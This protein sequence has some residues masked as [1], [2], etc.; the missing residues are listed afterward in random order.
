[1]I[2]V[3]AEPGVNSIVDDDQ[4][5]K[6]IVVTVN[7][8]RPRNLCLKVTLNVGRSFELRAAC[9]VPGIATVD[10]AGA[11]VPAGVPLTV[12]QLDGLR[13]QVIIPQMGRLWLEYKGIRIAR[14]EP[15]SADAQIM[16]LPLS[17]IQSQVAGLLAR[18]ADLDG[19]VR[20]GLHQNVGAALREIVVSW[21]SGQLVPVP[22]PSDNA[23]PVENQG[24]AAVE[25]PV[26]VAV[27]ERTLQGLGA[28]ASGMYL[29]AFPLGAPNETPPPGA[30]E[31]L[32]TG[33][34]RFHRE[35]C[36]SGP[37]LLTAWIDRR[38]C[39]RPLRIS[40]RMDGARAE[41]VTSVSPENQF[42]AALN[43]ADAASRSK[44]WDYVVTCMGESPNHPAWKPMWGLLEACRS[45]PMTTFDAVV[46]LTRNPEAAAMAAI[47]RPGEAWLWERLEQLPFLWSLVPIQAW[48]TA[49]TCYATVVQ[50][51]LATAGLT[52]DRI[53]EII[54]S[55][56][57][58]F[59][60]RA[61]L[62]SRCLECVVGCMGTARIPVPWPNPYLGNLLP[63]AS[64]KLHDELE[65]QRGRLVALHIGDTWP[66][67]A[68]AVFDATRP[69]IVKLALTDCR[70]FQKSVLDA[71]L[72][73]AAHA[74]YNLPIS[75][76]L[77][78]VLQEVRGFDPVWFEEA[79]MIAMY[80]LAGD[81]LRAETNAFGAH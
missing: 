6:Q 1:M 45:L 66:N 30:V 5:W 2:S 33:R 34:W 77:A 18:Q 69:L 62:Q 4:G 3:A 43:V 13:L 17:L 81:R 72:L 35:L 50:Q 57:H 12:G 49:A 16:E 22:S 36:S 37:W 27:P 29:T 40:V 74:I 26:E 53:E 76:K 54:G 63:G 38:T 60:E 28:R 15:T 48:I 20:I 73:A 7:G 47:Q 46:A 31:L 41:D 21:H 64:D 71:P 44:A 68:T 59:A 67:V 52:D 61:P 39:L 51:S 80:L 9:P 79:N 24:Q 8:T 32:G 55:T 56:F 58:V 42:V 11:E 78:A 70:G 25:G 23:T 75:T 19:T 14:L 10:A 65:R